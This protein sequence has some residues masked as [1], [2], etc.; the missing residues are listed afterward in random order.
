M[1]I[2]KI[3]RKLRRTAEEPM[4]ATIA[5]PDGSTVVIQPVT[6]PPTNVI[7]KRPFSFL[8][9]EVAACV[10]SGGNSD[11]S[12]VVKLPKEPVVLDLARMVMVAQAIDAPT[13]LVLAD[14]TTWRG[15]VRFPDCPTNG[16]F[17][18]PMIAEAVTAK[19]TLI[20]Q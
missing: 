16:L 2:H 20:L 11:G 18:D 1:P 4:V 5:M 7:R 12:L 9:W 3:D 10:G 19:G 17:A 6:I 15:S 14:G 8:Q 13:E